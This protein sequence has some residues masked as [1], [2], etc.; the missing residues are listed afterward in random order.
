LNASGK[1]DRLALPVPGQSAY[2]QREYE[3]PRGEVE[4]I[5]AGIWQELLKLERI[6]RQDNF[7]ELGGHSLSI[8]QMLERL[9][10]VGLSCE[11]R[12][13]FENPRLADLADTLVGRDGKALEVP[14]NLIPRGCR[15]IRPAML[16]LV[17]LDQEHIDRIA[18]AVPGG[19]AN[20]QDIYPLAPLQEGILFHHLLNGPARDAYVRPMLYETFSRERLEELLVAIQVVIDRH[21]ILRTMILWERLPRAVQVVCRRARLVVH[22]V[23]LDPGR[24]GVEQLEERMTPRYQ[25]LDL[26]RAPLIQVQTAPAPDGTRWYAL[27][28]THH[29][30]C[31]NESLD[32]L[33]A[34]LAAVLEGRAEEL[35]EPTPYRAHVAQ[36]LA[37]ARGRDAQAF[38]RGKLGD[39][40]EPTAP[41]G[42][43]DIRGDGSGTREVCEE[44]DVN[45]GKAL[46]RQARRLGVTAAT[47]FHAAWALV[48]SKVSGREDIV[49]GTVLSGRLHGSAGAQRVLG[50]FINTLP[51]RLK[52]NTLTVQG[53]IEHTQRELVELL[54]YEQA[55]LAEA[56]RCSAVSEGAPLFTALLNYR[57]S[58][59]ESSQA[60]NTPGLRLLASQG[61]TN[62]PIVLSVDDRGECFSL[63][64]ETARSLESQR[65]M[66]YIRTAVQSLVEALQQPSQTPALC[67]SILP[68][69]ERRQVL[70][71][72]NVTGG[73][74]P[75]GRLIHELF[76]DQ[77]ERTSDAMAVVGEGGGLRYCELNV[78]ANRL[79]R[80]LRDNGVGGGDLVGICLE[81]SVDLIVGLLAALKTGGGYVPLDPTYPAER[82]R[83]ILQDAR[84]K[85]V[86]SQGHLRE[87]LQPQSSA[88]V[89][90]LDEVQGEMASAEASNL[91]EQ[92]L[93][94]GEP[95]AYVIHT[96]GSTGRPKGV[97]V[98]HGAVVNLLHDMQG[99][100]GIC[101]TDRFLAVT[102]ISFDIAALEIFLPLLSGATV[103]V[104]S[105]GAAADAG[106]LMSLLAAHEATF[107]QAT[108]ATWR[109]LVEAG[110]RGRRDLTA[111]CGGE[112]LTGELSKRLLQRTAAVWNLYGPTET[113]IWSCARKISEPAESSQ[114][115][116]IGVPVTNTKIYILDGHLR[117]MPVG[118]GGEIYIAG[119]GVTRGY[120]N[121]PDLTA[122]RFVSDPFSGGAM[123]KSGDLGKWRPDGVI[124][125]LGRTDQQVKIRGFRIELAEIEAHLRQCACVKDAVAIAC[126]DTP[127]EKRLVAYVVPKAAETS[128]MALS[129]ETLR[130]QLK[131]VL[132][133]Y[134]VPSAWVMLEALP[135]TASG[136][137]DRRLL[138]RPDE[139]AYLRREY[140][141]PQGEVEKI[142]AGIWQ[143]VLNIERVGRN[144]N[145]FE[146]GGHSLLA[147]R[148]MVQIRDLMGLDLPLFEIFEASSLDDLAVRTGQL[149]L[150]EAASA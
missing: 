106:Q 42:L 55:S 5:L 144:D 17:E 15:Q 8:V 4:Q 110:W 67:L 99:R 126:G 25:Q 89:I 88:R 109:M 111:L 136:K 107:M 143:E 70:E 90:A 72:F 9:R 139:Q 148:V 41:F 114:V 125:Y 140:E 94:S 66:G 14:P 93:A 51:L 118:V 119:A 31:D 82:L 50:M 76:E 7:F 145:F 59:G 135:L 75:G 81:R 27:L 49:F 40:D 104:A 11:V 64:L 121:R 54:G 6:G 85:I 33:L 3:A 21:D 91:A 47:L 124:E 116:P 12:R 73:A 43:M 138:P 68:E 38:F 133:E 149:I 96:S 98:P 65:L 146:L 141:A 58:A 112:V 39:L 142:L 86:L 10:R 37:Y 108:P 63:E 61:R 36:A 48:I 28:C 130:A 19:A 134:M 80:V 117:P 24:D 32:V 34:E 95:V 20:I 122:E 105:R 23:T 52:L 2:S 56:Q 132:P 120:L 84:P 102:T 71:S 60:D 45:L 123:Y 30:V 115:E 53:L 16:P 131:A 22:P 46:R 62:Y 97:V 129:A 128:E 147:T 83:S 13:V 18:A 103:I 1:L 87:R 78:R 150:G 69:S 44:L 113:T 77:V 79:A 92:G 137:L 100:L 35:A 29:L 101:R 57:H 74:Y 26:C 127:G